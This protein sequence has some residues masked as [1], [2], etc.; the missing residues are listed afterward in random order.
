[1]EHLIYMNSEYET[2]SDNQFHKEI[3]RLRKELLKLQEWLLEN[4]KKLIVVFEGR[5]AAGKGAAIRR[6][7]RHLM[8]KHFRMVELGTPTKKQ[9][10]NWFGTYKKLLPKSGEIVFFDRSWYSRA[11]I[12]P[13]MGY[14]SKSQYNYFMKNIVDWEKNLIEE[15]YLLIKFYLSI[16]IKIQAQ[17]FEIRR[18]H[19]LKYWKLS[20]NDL[21]SVEHW[22]LYS[23][24]KEKMFRNTSWK[25]APWIVINANNKL[26]AQLNSIRYMLNRFDYTNKKELKEKSWTTD[27]NNRNLMFL[28]VRFDNLSEEQYVLL[29]RIKQYL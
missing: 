21:A 7:S 12:Q 29:S 16:N 15:G 14:C 17:R 23:S 3:F 11:L 6:I 26:I 10:K 8:T 27:E 18:N 13:T 20:T 5:D 1:M 24:F 9:N 25:E 22:E 2:L 28:D 4:D 19:E